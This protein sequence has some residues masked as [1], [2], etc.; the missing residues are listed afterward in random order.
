MQKKERILRGIP[1][2][3][4]YVIGKVFI[5]ENLFPQ[6]NARPISDSE[7]PSEISRFESAVAETEEDLKQL[8]DQVKR[9]MGRDL[10]EF[11]AI[12]IALLKDRTTIDETK[13]FIQTKKLNAEYAYA[14]VCKKLA[15]PVAGSSLAFFRERFVDIL[16]VTNRVLRKLLKEE[17]PSI[18][19]IRNGSIL[20]THDL[21]P[22]EAALLDKNRVLGVVTET[23]GKTAHSAILVKAKEIPTV[24]GVENIKKHLNS[25]ETVILDGFRGIV[26]LDPT[27]KRIEFYQQ[28]IEKNERRKKY[29]FQLKEADPITLDGKF[30]D[31]SANIEFVAECFQARQYGAR[32]IGLFRTEYLYLSK[33]RAPTEEEQYNV[34]AEVATAMKP[35]PVI[36]R[37][38]DLGGDKIIPGYTEGNPFLGWRAIRVCF[39]DKE[40]FKTQLRAI[41]RASAIGNVKVMFPMIAT[42]EEIKRAKILLNEAKG[43]L[44]AQKIPFNNQ[45]EIGIMIEVPSAALKADALAQ[46]CNF[47]SIGSNDLTQYTLAV[48]RTNERVAKLYD[49]S[50]PAVLKL[51]K[52]TID[53]AH[54]HNIWIGLCGELASDPLGIVILIGF[55]ID[56]LSMAPASVPL[57]KEIIRNLDFGKAKM[58]VERVQELNTPLEVTRYL[59]KEIN[60]KFPK[61][62]D[63]IKIE[64]T[65]NKIWHLPK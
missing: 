36:I 42:L 3:P 56:E 37:T 38:F 8:Y 53:A 33:R 10:A 25:G 34:F 12:Q 2:S 28:E 48:D 18:Y 23:G 4:G 63:K 65:L 11:I 43:E 45:I 46:E 14:E 30:I 1:V 27:E 26:I 29:L 54:R 64:N 15:A 57:A 31:L 61:L 47:F 35:Y 50:H 51:I 20:I 32:G 52:E 19:E 60:E 49:H 24:M 17:L 40:L 13:R 44:T 55:G 5:Y 6:L 7:I 9:E 22:S 58:M 41:L 21:L 62:F 16:D 39:D 59:Q